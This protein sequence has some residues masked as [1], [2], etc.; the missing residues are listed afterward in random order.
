MSLEKYTSN[1]Y[2]TNMLYWRNQSNQIFVREEENKYS[3]CISFLLI[4]IKLHT[5]LPVK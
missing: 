5:S 1:I 4:V 2:L 3:R